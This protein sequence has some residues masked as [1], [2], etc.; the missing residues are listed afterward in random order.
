VVFNHFYL[1]EPKVRFFLG[2]F[3]IKTYYLSLTR[4]SS[5]IFV[6]E[7]IKVNC[8]E[9]ISRLNNG[10]FN[11]RRAHNILPDAQGF[12]EQHQSNNSMDFDVKERGS[13]I[14]TTGGHYRLS[15]SGSIGTSADTLGLIDLRW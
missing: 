8:G 3:N 9:F 2:T 10:S 6:E 11:A 7:V 13:V 1:I 15:D 14:Y 5:F 4:K 12:K